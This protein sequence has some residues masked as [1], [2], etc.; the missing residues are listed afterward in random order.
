MLYIIVCSW[1]AVPKFKNS[2]AKNCHRISLQGGFK[3]GFLCHF[4]AYPGSH[5]VDQADIK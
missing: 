1:I 4:G 2:H 5:S 3:T